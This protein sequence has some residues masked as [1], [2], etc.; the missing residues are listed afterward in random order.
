MVTPFRHS[1]GLGK[2]MEYWIVGKMLKEGLDV[3]MPL[4]D[5]DAID[6][7]IRRPD[8]SFTTV[9]I[10]ARSKNVVPGDGALFAAIRHEPRPNY[11]FVL[12]SERMNTTWTPSSEEFIAEATQNKTGKSKGKRSIWFNGKRTDW[13]PVTSANTASR[14]SRSTSRTTCLDSFNRWRKVTRCPSLLLEANMT[15]CIISG[16]L[17]LLTNIACGQNQPNRSERQS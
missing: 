3:Y 2:R 12:Y 5:D 8:G 6:A 16:G 7:V 11:W 4:V 17:G 15:V 10:K 14:N 9:Q 13:R 1:A